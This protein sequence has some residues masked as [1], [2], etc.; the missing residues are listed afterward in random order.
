M[1]SRSIIKLSCRA[2]LLTFLMA[3]S[4]YVSTPT[5]LADGNTGSA[6]ADNSYPGAE[7]PESLKKRIEL[8]NEFKDSLE[9]ELKRK[10]DHIEKLEEAVEKQPQGD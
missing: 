1:N 7:T 2:A 10:D 5:V 8:L 4:F 3:G 9:K 6:T